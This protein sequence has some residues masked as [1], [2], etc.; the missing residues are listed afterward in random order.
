MR[1]RGTDIRDL[2]DRALRLSVVRAPVR[3]AAPLCDQIER[4]LGEE[5]LDV[6][7][8]PEDLLRESMVDQLLEHRAIRFD[9][10]RKRVAAG[11]LQHP[12][13]HPVD[14]GRILDRT[15]TQALD[16]EVLRLRLP[17]PAIPL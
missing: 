5:R 17:F 8:A 4:S 1:P 3:D 11:D 2:G 14:R 15:G 12:L 10:I 13:V 9:A 16:V 6:G 7:A